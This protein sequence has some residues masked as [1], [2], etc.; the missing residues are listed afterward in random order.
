M[1]I[2]ETV[3][4]A[5]TK[6]PDTRSAALAMGALVAAASLTICMIWERVVSSPTRVAWQRKKPDWLEVAADTRSPCDL[7]TG[8]LSPVRA[9][10]FTALFPSNTIPSTGIFSPGRTTKISPICTWS[11]ETSVS[12]PFFISVA[13]LGASFIRPFR[14]SVVR[15]LERASSILPTVIRV[16]IIAADSK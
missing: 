11:M 8:M 12:A 9:D 10:S 7:S 16:T 15:P 4:T 6:M 14:A 13:V 3:I 2:M 1:V 5:G